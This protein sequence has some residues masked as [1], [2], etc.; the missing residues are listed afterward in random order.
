MRILDTYPPR[1]YPEFSYD[2][3][4]VHSYSSGDTLECRRL[5][6]PDIGE[7]GFVVGGGSKEEKWL[8]FF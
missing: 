2:L 3:C 8:K 4:I 1:M 5:D 7:R 6:T